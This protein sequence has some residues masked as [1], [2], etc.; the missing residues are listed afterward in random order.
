MNAKSIFMKISPPRKEIYKNNI[1]NLLITNPSISNAEIGQSLGLHRST[2]AKYLSEMHLEEEKRSKELWTQL[3]KELVQGSRAR[4]MQLEE[5]WMDSYGS[6][7]YKP[8]QL[9]SI[10]QE[11]W[12]IQ[13]DIYKMQLDYLGKRS[14][15]QT[16]IQVNV[17]K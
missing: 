10:V 14:D 17:T 3:L 7:I 13:K 9:L 6:S 8:Q 2:I 4:M 12:K 15:P 1:Q 5:I 11:Y 16:L